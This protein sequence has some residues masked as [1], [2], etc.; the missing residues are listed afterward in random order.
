MQLVLSKEQIEYI[1]QMLGR[2]PYIEVYELVTII[3]S[4]AMQQ[5]GG[6]NGERRFVQR[7]ADAADAAEDV[8]PD[9]E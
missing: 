9:C 2:C 4:Q 3:K 7:N 6:G 5:L 1:L 8:R